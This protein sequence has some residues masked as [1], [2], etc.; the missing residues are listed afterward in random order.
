MAI[1]A[2]GAGLA[3]ALGVAACAVVV[4]AAPLVAPQAARRVRP[5][6][7]SALKNAALAA[8]AARRHMAQMSEAWDDLLAEVAVDLSAATAAAGAAAPANDEA[9]EPQ[10]EPATNVRKAKPRRKRD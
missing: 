7:K 5:L 2:R 1:D 9:P 6:A 4:L 3:F 10:T 8:V